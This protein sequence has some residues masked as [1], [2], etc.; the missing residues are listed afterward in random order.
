MR[1]SIS[2]SRRSLAPA[3]LNTLSLVTLAALL[4]GCLL[5]VVDHGLRTRGALPSL[6]NTRELWAL[7]RDRVAADK[8]T[9]SIVLMGASRM[10]TNIALDELRQRSGG[11]VH[12]LAVSGGAPFRMFEDIV[13]DTEFRGTIVLSMVSPWL[14]PGL[15]RDALKER[16]VDYHADHWNWARALDT[17]LENAVAARFVFS[18]P[19]YG[20][21]SVL[22]SLV[23]HGVPFRRPLYL[24]TAP[25]REQAL[26]FEHAD[27]AALR[28]RRVESTR[29]DFA[30]KAMPGAAEW[31]R[32]V[33]E[34]AA[35]VGKFR[36]RG[37]EVVLM[38]LP[39]SGALRD[40]E[41]GFAPRAEYWD[42]LARALP[43]PSLHYEDA[44][45]LRGFAL[46]DGSHIDATDKS[47]FTAAFA[48]ALEGFG[49]FD[50]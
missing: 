14:V 34:F 32:I 20:L 5:I 48:D 23:L 4:T 10:Q 30:G 7:A 33:A 28:K 42:S 26:M 16:F 22:S 38:R 25:D 40:V 13:E 21:R 45:A 2:S 36:A 15:G 9:D 49:V 19:H 11:R 1:S 44:P 31:E 24:T 50:R 46:P 41:E 6:Q 18:H 37:G 12:Q 47:A 35:L 27:R 8:A 43:G 17:R 29:E 3:R 39:S